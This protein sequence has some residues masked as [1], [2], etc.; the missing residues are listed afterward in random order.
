MSKL[1]KQFGAIRVSHLSTF[2]EMS[3][4]KATAGQATSIT[5][6]VTINAPAGVITTVS[7]SL[8]TNANISFT[9]GNS[10]VKADSVVLCNISNYSGTTGAPFSRVNGVTKGSFIIT[11]RNVHDLEALN[12]ALKFNYAVL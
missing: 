9:V 12:G 1:T 4:T 10:F 11:I 5:S 6:G 3:L 8:A 2:G 7:T